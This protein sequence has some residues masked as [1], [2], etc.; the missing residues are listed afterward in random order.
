VAILKLDV[1][2]LDLQDSDV[3]AGARTQMSNLVAPVAACEEGAVELW[4]EVKRG[5][6]GSDH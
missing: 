1:D 5:R 2:R 4:V 6:E 3:A